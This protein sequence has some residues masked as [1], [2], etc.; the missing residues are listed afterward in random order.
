MSETNAARYDPLP[1]L[2]LMPAWIWRRLPRAGKVALAAAPVVGVAA[3][4]V[5]HEW[6]ATLDDA[7]AR[8]GGSSQADGFVEAATLAEL[9]PQLLSSARSP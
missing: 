2:S 7:V 1:D 9:G 3:V 6:A 8:M 4:L 5:S